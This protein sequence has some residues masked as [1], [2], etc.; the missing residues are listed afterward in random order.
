MGSWANLLFGMKPRTST[1]L[2]Q[3]VSSG[4]FDEAVSLIMAEGG[5]AKILSLS[6]SNSESDRLN[7]CLLGFSYFRALMGLR[8]YAEASDYVNNLLSLDAHS[9]Q[10]KE[11][12]TAIKSGL[13]DRLKDIVAGGEKQL[14]EDRLVELSSVIQE[15]DVNPLMP[16]PL[17]VDG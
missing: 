7:A 6:V 13:S 10:W 8:R 15:T 2:I 17:A 12:L 4:Q 9:P 16:P 3:C 14:L 1:K 5:V 11:L